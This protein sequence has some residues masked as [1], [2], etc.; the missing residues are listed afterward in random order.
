MTSVSHTFSILSKDREWSV[1]CGRHLY[2]KLRTEP[3]SAGVSDLCFWSTI[4]SVA[5]SFGCVEPNAG[6]YQTNIDFALI[7]F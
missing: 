1:G 3:R 2:A 5:E 7:K 6:I 4:P